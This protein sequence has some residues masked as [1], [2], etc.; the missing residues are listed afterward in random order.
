[1]QKKGALQGAIL[2]STACKLLGAPVTF[3]YVL[4][5]EFSSPEVYERVTQWIFDA[6]EFTGRLIEDGHRTEIQGITAP[7]EVEVIDTYCD[8]TYKILT[9]ASVH[10]NQ[11]CG[12]VSRYL[13]FYF[14]YCI[15]YLELLYEFDKLVRSEPIVS[16][17]SYLSYSSNLTL[18]EEVRARLQ[19]EKTDFF[20]LQDAIKC[21]W[22][23]ASSIVESTVRQLTQRWLEVLK[24]LQANNRTEI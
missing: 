20:N 22:T 2:Y 8:N 16:S 11:E 9:K 18:F 10:A 12:S 19:K 3:Y 4:D 21:S 6:E 17:E 5:E 23:R 14:M 7:N 24:D 13:W 1:M 15:W